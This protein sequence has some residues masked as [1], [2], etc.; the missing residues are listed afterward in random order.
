MCSPRG[1]SDGIGL[2]KPA[3]TQANSVPVQRFLLGN[4]EGRRTLRTLCSA[5]AVQ[6]PAVPVR[7]SAC[8]AARERV[9]LAFL[10]QQQALHFV[11]Q[12]TRISLCV[13]F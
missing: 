10:L 4:G 6:S 1:C 7:A 2:S 8:L 3:Q 5:K 12:C 9:N 11:L 13:A